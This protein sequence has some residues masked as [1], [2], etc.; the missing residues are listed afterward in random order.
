MDGRDGRW[1]PRSLP[2]DAVEVRG[3][4][5]HMVVKRGFDALPGQAA[6]GGG[7]PFFLA[8]SG[9]SRVGELHNDSNFWRWTPHCDLS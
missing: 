5:L 6:A 9:L 2:D 3:D 8:K 1:R 4:S 7:A